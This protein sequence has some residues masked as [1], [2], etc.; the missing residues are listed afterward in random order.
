MSKIKL[1]AIMKT[2]K[3]SVVKHSPDI[4]FWMGIVGFVSTVVTAV[5]VTPKAMQLME[6]KKKDQ[7]EPTDE[8]EK[9][10]VKEVVKTTWKC[11]VPVAVTGTLSVA[12]LFGARKIS[13]KRNAILAT[14]FG[15]SEATL[16]EYKNKVVETIG[17]K[18]EKEIRDEIAADHIRENPVKSNELILPSNGDTLC[19]DMIS[20]QYFKSDIEKIRRAENELN[21]RLMSEMYIS[22]NEFYYELGMRS[23]KLGNELGWNLDDGLIDLHFSSHLT[24]N[25]T[26]CLVIDYH[27][28]PRYGYAS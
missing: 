1:P 8:D 20:G 6:E 21:R 12:C 25:G 9:L 2:A 5:K 23:T 17:E 7:E 24:E 19:Y 28:A 26:P 11:Y 16:S 14:A 27:I 15:L 10:P 18:K 4:L 22:L 3:R 13:M